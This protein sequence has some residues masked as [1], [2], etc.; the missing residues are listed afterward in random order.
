MRIVVVAPLCL[1]LLSGVRAQAQ[2]ADPAQ[3]AV[4]E[5]FVEALSAGPAAAARA[6]FDSY[7]VW[8]EYDL[9]PQVSRGLAEVTQRARALIDAGVR[10]EVELVG[11]HAGGMVLVTHE[12]MWGDFVSEEIAPLRSVVVY[13]VE[14]GRLTSVSRVL[15]PEQRDALAVEQLVRGT[16]PCNWWSWRYEVD[17]R[18]RAT[19][20]RDP[21]SE[22]VDCGS[23]GISHGVLTFV[24]DAD[25]R[26]CNPGDEGVYHVRFLDADRWEIKQ[27]AEAC[28]HRAPR[29]VQWVFTRTEAE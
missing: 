25:S 24:S 22:L 27:I 19:P 2:G 4:V 6:S 15:E 9:V 21:S 3:F 10:L 28:V 8:S 14:R 20:V 7:A 12:R 5:R 26:V 1:L 18:F 11:T 13:V 23:F 16:W 17:G 29:G